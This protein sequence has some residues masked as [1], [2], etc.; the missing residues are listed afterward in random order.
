MFIH[1]LFP[2]LP[3]LNKFS[4]ARIAARC[5]CHTAEAFIRTLQ[6]HTKLA[7]ERVVE[8]SALELPCS[9][10][11]IQCETIL[12]AESLE[13][14]HI[15]TLRH[16]CRVVR[17]FHNENFIGCAVLAQLQRPAMTVRRILKDD[18][19]SFRVN[20]TPRRENPSQQ[21]VFQQ[22]FVVAA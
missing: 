5:C 3:H 15:E 17:K 12:F 22:V 19:G 2:P 9:A 7:L 10:Q 8:E 14:P 20:F 21:H 1:A 13:P 16:C 6:S 11:I 4:S 18:E